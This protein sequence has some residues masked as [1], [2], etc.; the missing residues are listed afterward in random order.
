MVK[1]LFDI[2]LITGQRKYSASP[3][4]ARMYLFIL[5]DKCDIQSDELTSL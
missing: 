3:L 5:I 4:N 2:S 1:T